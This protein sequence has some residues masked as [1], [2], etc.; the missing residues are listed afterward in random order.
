MQ[1]ILQELPLSDG[2]IFVR[3]VI[4]YAA[5][6]PWLFFASIQQ[7]ILFGQPM[8]EKRYEKVNNCK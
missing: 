4:S 2:D 8:D 7:N 3:G 5:Q 1:A 6:E